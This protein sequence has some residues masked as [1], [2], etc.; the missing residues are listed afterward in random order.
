MTKNKILTH[1]YTSPCGE[2]LLAS[3]EHRLCMCDWV[4]SEPVTANL[5]RLQSSLQADVLTGID[6][7][8]DRTCRQLDAYFTQP[9][10]GFD[11]P[12]LLIGTPFQQ[13]VWRSLATIPY[14]T[15]IS[16][17]RQA[18]LLGCPRAVRAVA[19]ANGRN[20]LSIILPCHRVIG[21]NGKLTGY[22][23]GLEIKQWLLAWEKKQSGR[24]NN[25]DD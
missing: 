25:T 15:T 5:L 20:P 16:Y 9:A 13:Q 3:F 11:V 8:I 2:M 6:A 7:V 4:K 23:G 19:A 18:E 10:A 12:F 22:A 14:G 17:G 1:S 21:S 24:K